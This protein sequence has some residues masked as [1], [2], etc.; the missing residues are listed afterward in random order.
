[1]INIALMRVLYLLG[2]MDLKIII[3]C[4]RVTLSILKISTT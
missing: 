1:M 4:P 2:T 3:K